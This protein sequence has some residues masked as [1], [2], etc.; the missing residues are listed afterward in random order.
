MLH[1]ASMFL[2]ITPLYSSFVLEALLPVFPLNVLLFLAPRYLNRY[3][4]GD[5]WCGLDN[6][7]SVV[8]LSTGVR[9]FSRLQNYHTRL[10]PLTQYVPWQ[11]LQTDHPLPS[12]AKLKNEWRST[13]IP[14][15]AFIVYRV[16][17]SFSVHLW[18]HFTL[19][20]LSYCVLFTGYFLL[21]LHLT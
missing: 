20:S 13:P 4:Y 1:I 18:L 8:R 12:R 11:G 16:T 10:Q 17:M 6:Q 19:G 9:G 15:Y 14:P 3:A 2:R 7:D 21:F 5:L